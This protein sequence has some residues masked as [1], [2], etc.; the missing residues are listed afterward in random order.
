VISKDSVCWR[1]KL[2][3]SDEP[4]EENTYDR[5]VR[6]VVAA[7]IGLAKHSPGITWTDLVTHSESIALEMH[8][9]R[10]KR[11]GIKDNA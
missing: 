10:N 6:A 1:C 3:T 5:D 4:E 11:K 8:K 2:K 9:Q 7:M